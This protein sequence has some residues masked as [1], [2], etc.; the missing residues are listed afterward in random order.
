MSILTSDWRSRNGVFTSLQSISFLSVVTAQACDT[1]LS[2]G[3]WTSQHCPSFSGITSS[4]VFLLKLE[5]LMCP[6]IHKA[7]RSVSQGDQKK[8]KKIF[9]FPQKIL[10]KIEVADGDPQLHCIVF[11]LWDS[12]WNKIKKKNQKK[13]KKHKIDYLPSS[14][15]KSTCLAKEE[16]SK[17]NT[18]IC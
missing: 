15:G 11:N 9:F 1:D 18:L 16:F 6:I 8:K 13:P 2:S 14:H 5:I 17:L 10:E 3:F 4:F 12:R 7:H